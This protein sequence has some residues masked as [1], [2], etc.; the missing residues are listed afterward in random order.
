MRT[1]YA[2][3]PPLIKSQVPVSKL[4]EQSPLQNLLGCLVLNEVDDDVLQSVVVLRR[5]VLLGESQKASILQLYGLPRQTET[6]MS[7]LKT[8]NKV[9]LD[10][11]WISLFWPS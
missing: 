11:T 7:W 3:N 9:E 4:R 2:I 10:T 6:E 1:P 5:C 8:V